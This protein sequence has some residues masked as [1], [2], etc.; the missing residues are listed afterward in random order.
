[1]VSR[2]SLESPSKETKAGKKKETIISEK[3]CSHTFSMI[4][5]EHSFHSENRNTIFQQMLAPGV[6]APLNLLEK[7][8]V[9]LRPMLCALKTQQLFLSI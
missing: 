9:P 1:M 5:Q 3:N 6:R 2:L 4:V 7:E 8:M